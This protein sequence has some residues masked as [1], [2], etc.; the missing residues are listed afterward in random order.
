MRRSTDDV[1]YLILESIKHINENR[2]C[3]CSQ[4]LQEKSLS[5]K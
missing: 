5:E 4:I 2:S 3:I 1:R